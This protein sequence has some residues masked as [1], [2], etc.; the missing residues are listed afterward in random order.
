[1]AASATA[2]L[3][4]FSPRYGWHRDELYF[5]RAGRS[6]SWGFV[7]MPPFTPLVARLSESLFGLSVAGLRVAP[8]LALGAV[9]LLTALTSRVVGGTERAA[10]IAAVASGTCPLF[11]GMAHLL[12][13][14]AFD[15]LAWTAIAALVV[16][17]VSGPPR[18]Q[19]WLAVGAV[20]GV[21]LL[22]KHTV[23]LVVG[24]FVI[25][26]LATPQRSVMATPWFAAGVAIAVVMWAPNLAWHASHDWPVLEMLR[27]LDAEGGAEASL[28]FVPSQIA[29][30]PAV[31]LVVA[32]VRAAWRDERYRFVAIATALMV[33]FFVVTGGKPY[34]MAG[35]YPL[36]IAFGAVSVDA[37]ASRPA[38]VAAWIA[39][40]GVS[41]ALLLALPAL[42]VE[43]M[44]SHP[45]E[46]LEIE[47]GAQLGW[48]ELAHAV[49]D[50]VHALP[51]TERA[52]VQVLA[53]NY[54]EAAAVELFTD[55]PVASPHNQYWLWGPPR[56]S[57]GDGDGDV[58]VTIVVD[59]PGHAPLTQLFERCEVVRRFEPPHG[60]ASEEQGARLAVCRSPRRGWE[61]VWPSLRKY[62]A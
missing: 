35:V 42:P 18:P 45:I 15:L 53:S 22:N 12:S 54:G 50:E 44:R 14:A 38:A 23:A 13:T 41:S 47:V 6:L 24:A 55:L 31:V 21:G 25:G 51:A 3:L 9:V 30:G 20:V 29:V 8:A 33:V 27:S 40:G 4:A 1:M 52:R 5:V 36:L 58:D 10:L 60:V 49:A 43:W 39:A 11:L 34:Y 7:D 19:L 32:G 57:R 28:L 62:S 61:D 48:H 37:R 2:L 17:I 59:M 46:D 26:L 56:P 16:R